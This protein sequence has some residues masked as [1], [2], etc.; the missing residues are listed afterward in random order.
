VGAKTRSKSLLLLIFISAFNVGMSIPWSRQNANV[1][2][3]AYEVHYAIPHHEL[4]NTLWCE[5]QFDP[6]VI[7]CD[8]S[9][10]NSGGIMQISSYCHSEVA[11]NEALDPIWLIN[12][13]AQ[14]FAAGYTHE[15]SCHKAGDTS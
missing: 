4:S 8:D 9:I 5:S 7:H 10:S 11:A 1:I 2:I 3:T 15:W 13:T 12:W 6:I 14:R